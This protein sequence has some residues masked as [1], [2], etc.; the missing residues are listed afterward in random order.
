MATRRHGEPHGPHVEHARSR[1]E[2]P[3]AGQHQHAGEAVADREIERASQRRTFQRE[4]RER[5]GRHAHDLEPD[6]Q[7]E[8]VAREAEALHGGEE[9]QHR[10]VERRADLV[11]EARGER[12]GRGEEQ[13]DETREAGA[14]QL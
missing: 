10:D 8:Q 6:E 7:V 5:E 4:A 9:Q 3:D 2:Q 12:E 13:G 1:V 11:E 14:L